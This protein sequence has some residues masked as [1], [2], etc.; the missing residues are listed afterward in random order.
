VRELYW[1]EGRNL[2]F[3]TNEFLDLQ[4]Y[5]DGLVI[6]NTTIKRMPSLSDRQ[7]TEKGGLSGR[8]LADLSTA[9]IADM[10]RLT[11]GI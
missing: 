9:L 6:S 2:L 11:E 7:A 1:S 10:Y 5:I 3:G 4:C 8:P